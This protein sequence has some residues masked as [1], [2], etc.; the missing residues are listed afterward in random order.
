MNKHIKYISCIM[1]D[2]ILH[3]LWLRWNQ[4]LVIVNKN[5]FKLQTMIENRELFEK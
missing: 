4:I 1:E 2:C 5:F 3:I